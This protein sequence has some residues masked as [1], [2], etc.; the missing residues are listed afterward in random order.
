[1]PMHD[2]TRIAAGMFHDFHQAWITELRNGLNDGLLPDEYYAL[3]EQQAGATIPDVLTLMDSRWGSDDNPD[4]MPG[5]LEVM[6]SPPHVSVTAELE[7]QIYAWKQDRLAIH[8]TSDDRVVAIIEILSAGNKSGA[9]EFDRFLKKVTEA[10]YHG[11]H[12]LLVDPFPPTRRD[13]QGI[14]GAIWSELGDDNYVAP[15][16]KPLTQASYAA[17]L[18][19]RAYVEPLA[20]GNALAEMPLFLTPKFY[21]N[22]PLERTY[23]AAYRCV[24][25]RWKEVLDPTIPPKSNGN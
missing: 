15:P 10:V 13:P 19:W 9:A 18:P 6:L 12:L 1:M 5:V 23:Q 22:V 25:R 24:P 14:H 8:H 20:V 7:Q 11:I 16:E 4:K 17:D 21:V 2:W 3:A